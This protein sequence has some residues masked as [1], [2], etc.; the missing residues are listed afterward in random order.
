MTDIVT[1]KIKNIV[2]IASVISLLLLDCFIYSEDVVLDFVNAGVVFLTLFPCYLMGLLASGDVKLLMVTAMY[3]GL[4]VFCEITAASAAASVI[5]AVMISAVRHEPLLKI[6]Y[7][8][9]FA[10]LLGAMPLWF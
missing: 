6:E 8:F 4:S 7:P 9:A 3:A 10:L 5:L 1:F 2:L